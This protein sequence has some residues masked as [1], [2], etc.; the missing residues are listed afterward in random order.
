MGAHLLV[1]PA[2]FTAK[3][4]GSTAKIGDCDSRMKRSVAATL[5]R[6]QEEASATDNEGSE[7]GKG[8]E[9]I[10]GW[11]DIDGRDGQNPGT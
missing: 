7:L 6:R 5:S 4:I 8:S 1:I 10:H 2:Y 11:E 3:A 9:G